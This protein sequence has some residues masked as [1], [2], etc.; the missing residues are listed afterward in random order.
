VLIQPPGPI[1]AGLAD[2]QRSITVR[3][4]EES[5]EYEALIDYAWFGFHC[6]ASFFL[7]C[8][9]SPPDHDRGVDRVTLAK[10][11]SVPRNLDGRGATPAGLSDWIFGGDTNALGPMGC[12][13][14]MRRSSNKTSG[15]S[16]GALMY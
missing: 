16:T 15:F 8:A 11:P 9:N 4:E 13:V 12:H 10:S 6:K 2:V 14:W 5:I 7:V 3:G 1:P